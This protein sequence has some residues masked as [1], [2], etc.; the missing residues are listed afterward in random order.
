MCLFHFTHLLLFLIITHGHPGHAC[1]TA[2]DCS[3]LGTCEHNVCRCDSGWIGRHCGHANLLPLNITHGY[4]NK[5]EASWGGRPVHVKGKWHLFSTEITQ[6]CPLILFMN[7]SQ[8]VRCMSSIPEGPYI[9][10]EVALLPFHHNPQ[11]IG[12]TPDGYYLLFTIGT[13]NTDDALQIDCRSGVP[14]QCTQR[15]NKYCRGTHMPNSNGRI[16]LAWSQTVTGPWFSKIILPFNASGNSTDWNCENNNPTATILRN[17]TILMVYRANSCKQSS[18]GGA[19]AGGEA[20]GVAVASHWNGTYHRRSH[21]LITPANDTGYH[22][23]PFLWQDHRGSFHLLTH[24]QN[25]HN[26]CGSKVAGSSCGAHLFSMDSY[27]W[28]VGI[29]AVYDASVTLVNGTT[30]NYQTRQR[31]QIIFNKDMEPTHLFNG[32]GFE[33]PNQDCEQKT[34]TYVQAFVGG[35]R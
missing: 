11:I 19:G 32:G 18:G 12:P 24:N 20:L 10:Q 14:S 2:H 35:R 1:Q 30:T 8:V 31:P 28:T 23:D 34:H 29:D 27:T 7:N 22:E 5:N 33:G 17:G 16:N 4:Q 21:P 9:R 13:T 6:S 3:L 26:R 15:K 25:T